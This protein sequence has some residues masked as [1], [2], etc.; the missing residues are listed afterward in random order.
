MFEGF[1]VAKPFVINLNVMK[2]DI[3][4]PKGCTKL[5]IDIEKGCMTVY[6]ESKINDRLYDCPETGETEERPRIGDF[7]IFWNRGFKERACCANFCGMIN[8]KYISSSNFTYDE[9]IKLR[10]YDQYLKLK[11]IHGED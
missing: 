1:K 5:Q 10:S 7:A 8:G 9:A 4:I 3:E 2:K 11:G 6:Y